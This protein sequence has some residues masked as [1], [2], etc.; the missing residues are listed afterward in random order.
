MKIVYI[1]PHLSTGGCPQF[2]LKKIQMLHK[3]HEVHCIEYNDHGCFTVQKNQIKEI[4]GDRLYRVNDRKE[5]LLEIIGKVQPDVVHLEE[6]PEYFMDKSIAMKLYA[7][8]RKY[9]LIETS[10]D[11][12]FD[13]RTK[14]FFPD[15]FIFVSKF[16][17]ENMKVLGIP[18][19]VCEYPIV[20]IPRKPREEALRV[21]GQDPKKKH[22][23]HVGL[24]TPRKNQAEIIDYAK[25]LINYPV[26]FHFVGN[27]AENFKFYWEPL[28]KNFP[29]NCT[30]WNERKDVGNFY[31]MADLFLFPSKDGIG[32]K[33]TSPLVIREAISYNIPTLIYNSPV[34]MGMYDKFDGVEYLDQNSKDNNAKKILEML[35]IDVNDI[36]PI[37]EERD[38]DIKI[39]Y[40]RA[41]NKINIYSRN[42]I[43]N[44]LLS[45][46]ELDSK[47]VLYASPYNP[48]HKDIKYWIIPVPKGFMDFETDKYFGGILVELYSGEKLIYSKEFRIKYPD[49]VKPSVVLKNNTS[50]SYSNYM[51]FF[52]HKIYDRYLANKKFD[53][54]V[55]VGANIGLWAEYIRRASTCQKIYAVEPNIQALEILTRSFT[56]NEFIVVDKALTDKDGELEFFVDNNNSTIGATTK[57]GSLQNS[58]KVKAV[59]FKTFLHENNIKHVDLFKMDIEGGEYSFFESLQREDLDKISNLMIEFHLGN[60]RTME[61]DVAI[62]EAL[63]RGAGFKNFVSK[64]HDLGGFVFATK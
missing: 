19:E 5:E 30:W 28:M 7:K 39:D 13:P 25:S 44:A 12:S 27:Q 6:M 63:F 38:E 46:K 47:Q 37:E 26:Q 57:Q 1:S 40:D 51:E 22:I 42:Q 52:V 53:T 23:V 32:D 11:S 41:D 36:I 20:I 29:K 35:N 4:L 50:P 49:I 62:L 16:Q 60:G 64:E 45:I 58:Y 54:V 21:L 15:R 55:D 9:K 56:N 18:S 24:F 59:S 43:D 31:Q 61:K 3:D 33:E 14:G 2:L 8:D 10:H 17:E 34:Y 48:L